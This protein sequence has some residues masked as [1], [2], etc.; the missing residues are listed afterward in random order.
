MES[1]KKLSPQVEKSDPFVL[2]LQYFT[3][4]IML[5]KLAKTFNLFFI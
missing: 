4:E 2:T 3:E 1:F 5:H